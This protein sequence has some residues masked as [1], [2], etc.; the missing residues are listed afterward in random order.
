MVMV[1]RRP[2]GRCSSSVLGA[3]QESCSSRRRWR[4]HRDDDA[5]VQRERLER[6]LAQVETHCPHRHYRT[7]GRSN[8]CRLHGCVCAHRA[9]RRGEPWYLHRHGGQLQGGRL[10]GEYRFQRVESGSPLFPAELKSKW[11]QRGAEV[12]GI[13]A[14]LGAARLSIPQGCTI[15]VLHYTREDGIEVMPT[16]LDRGVDAVFCAAGDYCAVGLLSVATE[17][18]SEYRKRSQSSA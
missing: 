2:S 10:A 18:E 14:A 15:E 12:E 1:V 11:L 13:P 7:A 8:G 5:D 16:L 9:H 6:A 17:R 4:R 3:P